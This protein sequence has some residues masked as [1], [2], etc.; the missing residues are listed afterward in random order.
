MINPGPPQPPN[1]PNL[2]QQP[3][4]QTPIIPPPS[5]VI[6]INNGNNNTSNATY[7]RQCKTKTENTTRR[8]VGRVTIMWSFVLAFVGIPCCL[9]FIPFCNDDCKDLE[10]VCMVCDAV[11]DVIPA[12]CC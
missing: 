5:T 11:K 3:L 10:V 9:C 1:F 7:C 8:K 12:Q 6:F 2:G 4:H